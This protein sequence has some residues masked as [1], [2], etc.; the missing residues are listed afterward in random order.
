[1]IIIG[2]IGFSK[3]FEVSL[4]L[5]KNKCLPYPVA[6]HVDMNLCVI[7]NTVFLPKENY[8]ADL[9]CEYGYYVKIIR[10]ELENEYPYDVPLNCKSIGNTVIL[11]RKTVSKDILEFCEKSGKK[12]I[13]VPQGYAACSCC[14]LSENAFITSDKGIYNALVQ[15]G[16][17]PLLIKEG[18]IELKPYNYGFIGGA[19][20]FIGD[21]LYFFGDI[22]KHAD[23]RK[24][25]CFLA[26]NKIK[27][28]YFDFP[29]TDIG[30]IIEI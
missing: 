26:E 17:S 5:N 12:I 3:Y 9:F 1:M 23:Y 30:G 28:K 27:Y 18:Y 8:I 2:D 25:D 19:S 29:L 6:S 10:E 22:T 11:N 4:V 13:D 14:C 21:T 16:L 15:N 20:G 7:D 24:I